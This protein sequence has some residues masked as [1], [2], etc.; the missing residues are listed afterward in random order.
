MSE[1]F[2]LSPTWMFISD[3]FQEGNVHEIHLLIWQK[4]IAVAGFDQ[5]RQLMV[6]QTYLAREMPDS[7]LIHELS[8]RH[9]LLKNQISKVNKI[10][11][12]DNRFLLIPNQIHETEQAEEWIQKFHFIEPGNSILHFD[13][14]YS[15]DAKLVCPINDDLKETLTAKFL[16]AKI[17]PTSKFLLWKNQENQTQLQ[18]Q[19]FSREAIIALAHDGKLLNLVSYTYDSPKDLTYKIA[20]LISEYDLQH[21]AFSTIDFYGLAPF[22]NNT[23]DEIRKFFKTSIQNKNSEEVS[24]HFLNELVQC[25]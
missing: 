11:Y 22:W 24:I 4:G 21:D 12:S 20:R 8:E 19:C 3:D 9:T 18:I 1:V 13:L 2:N 25:E 10:W 16:N 14:K 6:A 7:Q 5:Q 17:E 23:I 15:A